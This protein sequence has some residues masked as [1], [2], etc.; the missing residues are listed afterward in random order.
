MSDIG[1]RA[2]S[3]A[4]LAL[5]RD[6]IWLYD[7]LAALER[8][9]RRRAAFEAIAA[10]ERRH[11]AIWEAKLRSLGEEPPS[12]RRPSWRVR[13]IAVLARLLGTRAVSDMV[14]PLEGFEERVYGEHAGVPEVAEIAA[15]EAKHAAIWSEQIGR[16]HV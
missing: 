6:A 16:A 11:A 2:A 5:E 1:N 7:A 3:L 15:D 4:G 10:S 12:A 14:K 9:P 13:Q 8:D